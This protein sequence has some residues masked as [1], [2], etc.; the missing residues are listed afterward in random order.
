MPLSPRQCTLLVI[1][2]GALIIPLSLTVSDP[3]MRHSFLATGIGCLVIG[4]GFA[5]WE[6]ERGKRFRMKYFKTK[7]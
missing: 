6:S 5:L 2:S 4:S 3:S 1:V 7:K